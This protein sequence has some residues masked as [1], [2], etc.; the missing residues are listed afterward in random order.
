MLVAAI[1][2]ILVL[3]T[4]AA[5]VMRKRQVNL[6]R[7]WLLLA[8]VSVV[9]WVVTL[10][11]PHDS[12]VPFTIRNWF[13]AGNAQISLNFAVNPTNWPIVFALLTVHIVF[14]F[15]SGSRQE[16]DQDFIFWILETG[17][18]A[19]AYFTV[20]AVDMWTVIIAWTAMDIGN[21]AYQFFIQKNPTRSGVIVDRKS[22]RLNS[23]H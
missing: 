15:V 14:L 4:L 1:F 16:L 6:P 11:I 8:V 9:V 5:Y 22:T 10:I 20:T 19:L 12:I 18:I 17:E 21:L 3:S 2:I 7:V 13:S 23:S